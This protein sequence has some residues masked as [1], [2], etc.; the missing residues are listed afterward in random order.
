MSRRLPMIS[1]FIRL[2]LHIVQL[3]D[4]RHDTDEEGT[5]DSIRKNVEF[6]SGNS[7]TLVFAIFIASIG[8]NTNSAAVII[9]AMLISPLMGPIV[10][11][12]LSLGIS[13]FPLLRR[14]LRNLGI[15]VLISILTST[16]YFWLS[17]L[18]DAQ[19]E[20]LARTRPTA[21]DVLIA[22]FG[23]A[24]G[25]VASSRHSK[26][27]A[28]PGV[29]IATALMPPLCTAGYGIASGQYRF[30][31]GALYL[32]CINSIYICLS[33]YFFTRVLKFQRVKFVDPDR[34]KKINRIAAFIG[35]ITFLPSAGLAW[36]FAQEATL[37]SRI[38]LFVNQ[39]LHLPGVHVLDR[40]FSY[41]LNSK[42]LTLSLIGKELSAEQIQVIKDKMVLYRLPGV[43]LNIEQSTVEQDLER[44]ITQKLNTEASVK[45]QL[46]DNSMEEIATLRE[47]LNRYH[48]QGELS[49]QLSKEIELT[50]PDVKKL[51][52]TYVS[53]VTKSAKSRKTN[54]LS[55]HVALVQWRHTPRGKKKKILETFLKTR[56]KE[57]GLQ[58]YYI[59]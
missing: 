52:L 54:V 3:F 22:I 43:E 34:Q 40:N 25:I 28:I 5:I 23:G 55:K 31:F 4:L 59:Q 29:A 32:F 51:E 11:A 14:S 19:S 18:G 20:L 35:V 48:V 26:G 38:S 33:T 13:D 57:N 42:R 10:G 6:E 41:S 50:M 27:N 46:E 9:G 1:Q 2:Q 17:P 15:A 30:F 56:L 12:G 44:R 24:S 53:Q 49:E 37:N 21:F 16:L 7:W 47:G 8:L 36:Y 45:E 58:I 39:E